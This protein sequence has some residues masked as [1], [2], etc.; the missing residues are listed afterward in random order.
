MKVNHSGIL[1]RSHF[2]VAASN[3]ESLT[4][5]FCKILKFLD[6]FRAGHIAPYIYYLENMYTIQKYPKQYVFSRKLK[7][8]QLWIARSPWV[9]GVCQ[10]KHIVETRPH[11]V[12]A[13]NSGIYCVQTTAKAPAV[14]TCVSTNYTVGVRS[15]PSDR[16]RRQ[17]PILNGGYK[18]MWAIFTDSLVK[19]ARVRPEGDGPETSNLVFLIRWTF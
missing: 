18:K 9:F 2:K 15:C 6:I 1:L 7:R 3:L 4:K 13:E 19:M 5:N 16:V 14:D 10:K 17:W 8:F 12:D 11:P